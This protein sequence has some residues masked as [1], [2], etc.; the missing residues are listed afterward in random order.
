[1]GVV[2]LCPKRTIYIKLKIV[3]SGCD[4]CVWAVG[5]VTGHGNWLGH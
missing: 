2:K 3:A 1:M 5:A 4:Q